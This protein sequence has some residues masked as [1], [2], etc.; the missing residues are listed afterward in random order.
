VEKNGCF[1]YPD[2]RREE[3]T[4]AIL[5]RAIN[6]GETGSGPSYDYSKI[7]ASPVLSQEP[8]RAKGINLEE[9]KEGK[10]ING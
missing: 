4:A 6:K 7:S 9:K 10:K 8:Q 3:I 5:K 2:Q 1:E